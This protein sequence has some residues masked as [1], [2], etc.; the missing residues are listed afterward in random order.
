MAVQRILQ[1]TTGSLSWQPLDGDGEPGD[2]GTVTVGVVRSAGT[3]VIAAGTATDGTG[4]APRTI[5]LTVAQS[6]T[7]DVLTATWKVG[8]DTIAVTEHL[9]VGGFLYS[10]SQLRSIEPSTG[11]ASRDTA[12]TGRRVR[13]EVEDIFESATGVPWTPRFRVVR[14]LAPDGSFLYSGTRFVRAV[15]W[16][17]L[18]SD[19]ETYT[20]LTADE[21][22]AIPPSEDGWL[23]LP[24]SVTGSMM[25]TAGVE[26]GYFE[27]SP[28]GMQAPS[29]VTREAV[30][31]ARAGMN[32]A[33]AGLPDRATSM[34]MSDGTSVT[35]ATPGVGNWHTGI[36]SVD[37]MLLRRDRRS[38]GTWI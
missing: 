36:P 24:Y 28:V 37:E 15:R 3:E 20:S 13:D 27:A 35:L 8:S 9:I 29:D 4:S 30:V 31:A 16:C 19:W 5:A 21:C 10:L 2:P 1:A 12:E 18:W 7:L 17:R 38:V 6:A 26:V 34:S 33:R 25:I 32:K 11:D 14:E 22:A 23:R